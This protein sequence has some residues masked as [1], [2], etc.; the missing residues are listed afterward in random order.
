[1]PSRLHFRGDAVT[2]AIDV[3]ATPRSSAQGALRRSRREHDDARDADRSATAC[4]PALTLAPGQRRLRAVRPAHAAGHRARCARHAGVR[5]ARED[6]PDPRRSIGDAPLLDAD[7]HRARAL[8]R[9]LLPGA[10]LRRRRALPPAGLR[11]QGRRPSCCRWS[12]RDELEGIDL[13]PRQ[14]EVLEALVAGTGAAIS[15]TCATA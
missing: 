11:A 9:R 2:A 8:D 7:A 6:P 15:M 1:M 12:T 4:P 10:D 13:T 3:P 5:G 14:R